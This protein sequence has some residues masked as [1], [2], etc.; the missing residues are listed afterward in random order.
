[1][2]IGR[3]ETQHD[4]R[5]VGFATKL[6]LGYP[7]LKKMGISVN[8]ANDS[9]LDSAGHGL[10]SHAVAEKALMKEGRQWSTCGACEASHLHKLISL[11]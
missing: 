11:S 8:Y 4:F 1:M 7:G 5:V 10:Y 2:L 6:M 9:L 3:W